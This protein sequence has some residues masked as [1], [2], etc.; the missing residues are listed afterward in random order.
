MTL[1]RSALRCLCFAAMMQL[2]CARAGVWVID[3]QIGVVGDYSTNAQLLEA[4]HTA[5][6]DGALL[7]N[8][9]TTYNGDA[10][11]LLVTP[12]LRFSNSTGYSAVTSDY[13]RLNVKSEFDAERSVFTASAGFS[14]DSSLYYDYLTSGG[15]GVR[16]DSW[17]GDLN[18]DR[19]FTERTD[20]DTDV[21]YTHVRYDE[22]AGV[23]TLTDYKYLSISPTLSWSSSERGKLTLS[24]NIGRYD[25]LD[26]TTSSRSANVQLGFVR[27]L[28]E[29]WSLT[30]AVGHSRATNRLNGNE[31]FL[32]F[33]QSGPELVVVPY[34][35]ESAQNGTVYSVNLSRKGERL[36]VNATASRQLT[37]SGFDYLAL[38]TEYEFTT[39][40]RYSERLSF[41]SDARY[42]KSQTPQQQAT[43]KYVGINASWRWTERWTTTI[44]AS[45]VT[46]RYSPPAGAEVSSSEVSITLSRQFDRIKFQ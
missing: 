31:E 18:W 36:S 41:G 8:A 35:V 24:G 22:G 46:E 44:G 19:S 13:E 17:T 42:V 30:S 23:A 40:Y 28:S 11:R 6:T 32:E 26:G 43:P 39:T 20:L 4:P 9:P 12:S 25:S 15:T 34:T 21:N 14:Q 5:E 33:T 1:G 7:L 29:I 45:Y 2:S 37:P 16:R 10:F 27:Q 38:L 3:P